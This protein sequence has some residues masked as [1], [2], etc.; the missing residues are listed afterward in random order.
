M[1]HTPR[2][3]ASL[4]SRTSQ[5]TSVATT[6]APNCTASPAARRWRTPDLGRRP[7]N[8]AHPAAN[9]QAK[10]EFTKLK[11]HIIS[12]QIASTKQKGQ[13]EMF[14]K[15]ALTIPTLL[16]AMAISVTGAGAAVKAQSAPTAQQP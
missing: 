10:D 7:S 8:P 15:S 14:T 5:P 9:K 3:T 4:W 13:K 1:T 6:C 16:L 2:L 11:V 12:P